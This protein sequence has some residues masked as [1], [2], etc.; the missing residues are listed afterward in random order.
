MNN[1]IIS[2]LSLSFRQGWQKPGFFLQKPKN[3]KT[4]PGFWVLVRK[5]PGFWVFPLGFWVFP[6]VSENFQFFFA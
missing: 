5:N 2:A 3:P 1:A 6:W 4:H